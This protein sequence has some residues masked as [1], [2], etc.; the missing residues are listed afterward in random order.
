MAGSPLPTC[1]SPHSNAK[2]RISEP[3]R[4][5]HFWQASTGK[6]AT[7]ASECPHWPGGQRQSLLSQMP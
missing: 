7:L 4:F 2:S 5:G 3:R 1:A 6:R